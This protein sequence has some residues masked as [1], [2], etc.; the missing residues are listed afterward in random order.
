[1]DVPY[2]R[3]VSIGALTLRPLAG[4]TTILFRAVARMTCL[5]PAQQAAGAVKIASAVFPS[6]PARVGIMMRLTTAEKV[7]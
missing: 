1:M 7:I 6:L 3:A 5:I 2:R 4:V